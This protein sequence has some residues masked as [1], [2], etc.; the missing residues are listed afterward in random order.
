[1]GNVLMPFASGC[2]SVFTILYDKKFYTDLNNGMLK[3]KPQIIMP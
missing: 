3:D 2:Q 1:M